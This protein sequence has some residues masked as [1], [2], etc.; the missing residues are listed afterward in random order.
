MLLLALAFGFLFWPLLRQRL[1]NGRWSALGIAITFAIVPVSLG[2]Y[3]YV[4]NWDPDAAQRAREG[5]KLVDELAARLVQSPDDVAGW[6]LLC[7]SYV[8]LGDYE[9][10]VRACREAWNR[11]PQ[12]DDDLKLTFGEAQILSD[13]SSLSGDA[14]RLVEEVL[15]NEPS[16]PKALWYGGLVAFELGHE[17]DVKARWSR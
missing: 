8:A 6:K 1:I 5:Q 15:T 3:K 16:N 9:A 17:D 2:L 13:R 12:P 7:R 10:A 4:S 14:G 11:T